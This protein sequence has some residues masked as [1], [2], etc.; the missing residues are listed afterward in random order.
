M[1]NYCQQQRCLYTHDAKVNSER[2]RRDDVWLFLSVVGPDL[3]RGGSLRVEELGLHA[4][5]P[6]VEL[7]AWLSKAHH[8]LTGPL[9]MDT[10][11]WT[12]ERPAV[13]P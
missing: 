10:V 3:R 7:D 4:K 5:I 11:D 6:P 12:D 13:S 2:A 8:E 9:L 1:L